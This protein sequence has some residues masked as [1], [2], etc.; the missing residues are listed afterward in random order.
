MCKQHT[1]QH[2][3][4]SSFPF[5]PF[6]SLS[7]PFLPFLS[8]SFPFFPFPSLSFPSSPYQTKW[9][10][11]T[12][13]QVYL[14]PDKKKKFE[15]KVHRKTL[16]PVFNETFN[17]KVLFFS[18]SLSFFP[19]LSIIF[20]Y[21]SFSIMILTWIFFV[22]FH[23]SSIKVPYAE[24]T[25]KTL[26]FAVYDF[27][28]WVHFS[29]TL[30]WR[31]ILFQPTFVIRSTF[32]SSFCIGFHTQKIYYLTSVLTVKFLSEKERERERE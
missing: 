2:T 28:R 3:L 6:P 4:I 20:F 31:D 7:F 27:D 15:T 14:L 26:V 23:F 11:E 21:L 8:L 32:F 16:N 29:R 18:L 9:T 19:H 17:F 12:C 24:I 5:F 25:T 30:F 1:N 22:P 10:N 13:L